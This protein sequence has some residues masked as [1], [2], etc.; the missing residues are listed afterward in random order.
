MESRFVF[1]RDIHSVVA[2]SVK[3]SY[4]KRR[5]KRFP[6]QIRTWPARKAEKKAR[7]RLK[8]TGKWVLIFGKRSCK[9]SCNGNQWE[10]GA[11]IF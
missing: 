5:K 9:M 7:E 4:F 8:Y 6:S 3:T 2:S 10:R 1:R 11:R